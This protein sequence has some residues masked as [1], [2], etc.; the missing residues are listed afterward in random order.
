M[1][2]TGSTMGEVLAMSDEELMLTRI[3]IGAW[4]QAHSGGR[5]RGGAGQLPESLPGDLG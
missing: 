5:G 3:A 4:R 1:H 2:V